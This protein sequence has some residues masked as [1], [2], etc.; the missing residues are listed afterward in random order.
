MNGCYIEVPYKIG[1]VDEYVA[2]I[3]HYI[4]LDS[5][6]IYELSNGLLGNRVKDF[7]ISSKNLPIIIKPNNNDKDKKYFISYSYYLRDENKLKEENKTMNT[8]VINGKTIT[9]SGS[10]V[11]IS[12]NRVIVDGKTVDK[13][14]DE[15]R[16]VNIEIYGDVQS[17]DSSGSV[18]VNG[19][20]VNIDCNGSCEVSGNV[21]GDID[22][23]G[24]V[25]CSDVAGNIS[26]GGNVAQRI[27]NYASSKRSRSK[28]EMR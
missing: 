21:A 8:I 19:D 23:N 27:G 22:A 2:P 13:F 3:N 4:N 10:N 5:I 24:S 6:R 1:F 7:K 18:K 17:L 11:I 16:A 25:I 9:C 15:D 12:N 14:S 28:Y 20:V 26:A